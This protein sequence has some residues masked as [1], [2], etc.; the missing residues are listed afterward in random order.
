MVAQVLAGRRLLI[1]EDEYVLAA[2][3]CTE[4]S[5]AGATII[6]PVGRLQQAFDIVEAEEHIDGAVLDINLKGEPVFPLADLLIKRGVPIIFATGYDR[7]TFPIR[8]A[9][10][11]TCVK[12]CA[13]STVITF[14]CREIR[15]YTP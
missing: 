9:H 10:I 4:L 3:L 7:F 6:G 14:M 1:A 15:A 8:F 11:A 5:R 2:E 12:P 13:I